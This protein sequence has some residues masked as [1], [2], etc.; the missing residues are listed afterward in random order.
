MKEDEAD[1]TVSVCL[2]LFL[3]A[4]RRV[5]EEPGRVIG[6]V[7]VETAFLVGTM[8]VGVAAKGVRAGAMSAKVLHTNPITGKAITGFQRTK[9]GFLRKSQETKFIGDKTTTYIKTDKKG[10]VTVW[11]AD[12][13]R[14]IKH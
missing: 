2:I 9:S 10:K 8:G 5:V 4:G 11:R 7:A 6:E 14:R 1:Q 3:L 12:K 13:T